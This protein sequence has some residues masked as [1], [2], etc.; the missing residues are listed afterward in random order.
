MDNIEEQFRKDL[1]DIFVHQSGLG[2]Y[3]ITFLYALESQSNVERDRGKQA[4]WLTQNSPRYANYAG[5]ARKLRNQ[6]EHNLPI[7]ED[8]L[9]D[10]FHEISLIRTGNAMLFILWK[11]KS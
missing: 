2:S 10:L 6:L 7:E 3:L 1:T 4:Y 8:L 5:L 11:E 9:H